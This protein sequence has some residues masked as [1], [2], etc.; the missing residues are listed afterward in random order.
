ME[1]EDGVSFLDGLISPDTRRRTREQTQPLVDVLCSPVCIRSTIVT[2]GSALLILTTLLISISLN[3]PVDT[4]YERMMESQSVPMWMLEHVTDDIIRIHLKTLSSDLMEGRGTGTRGEELAADYIASHFTTAGLQPAAENGSFY[5]AVP[6]ASVTPV[7]PPPLLIG[8]LALNYAEDYTV[9]SDF[10]LPEVVI[11]NTD[12]VFIGYGIVATAYGWDDY[13]DFDVSGK[14]V[15]VLANGP[16]DVSNNFLFAGDTFTYYGRWAYKLEQARARGAHGV[17]L[18]HTPET[19]GYGWQVVVNTFSGEQVVLA[20]PPIDN[21]LQFKGWIDEEAAQALAQLHGDS[22]EGWL[23]A[24]NSSSFTP[25]PL[26]TRMNLMITYEV[27]KFTGTNV[28]GRLGPAPEKGSK[29][30]VLMAHHDHLGIRPAFGT[31]GGDQIYNGAVDNASGVAALLAAAYALGS[32][33]QS[34]FVV[35]PGLLP[36][37]PYRTILFVSLTGE[38]SNLLGSTYFTSHP[39]CAVPL[40]GAM[41]ALNF[42]ITNVWGRTKDMAVFGRGLSKYMDEL[43]DEAVK[44]EHVVLTANPTPPQLSYLFRSD[45]LTFALHDIPSITLGGGTTYEGKPSSYYQNVSQTYIAQHYHQPSDDYDPAWSMGG[46]IQQTRIMLRIA[47]RLATM[48]GVPQIDSEKL[49]PLTV[50]RR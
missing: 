26:Q 5:Q 36:V 9:S 13:K 17:V 37:L 11:N 10:L 46:V 23:R 42:D 18:I 27:R 25:V 32:L 21:P 24:A 4:D 16:Y 44:A 35:T 3:Q 39:P 49:P 19:V 40:C 43:V 50:T 1:E 14:I 47:Y 48:D 22:L 8:S 15:V 28:V 12:M 33:Q 6:L 20:D 30:V 45:Q 2:V 7:S 41:S 31:S 34:Q 38:E 29:T